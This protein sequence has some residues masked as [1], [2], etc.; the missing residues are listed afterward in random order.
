MEQTLLSNF[1]LIG[2]TSTLY[3]RGGIY[4]RLTASGITPNGCWLINPQLIE[5][6]DIDIATGTD[7]YG[8]EIIGFGG[9]TGTVSASYPYR[10]KA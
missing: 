2:N 1:D 4:Y 8:S 9:V 10:Y 6:I 3:R 7:I 5:L